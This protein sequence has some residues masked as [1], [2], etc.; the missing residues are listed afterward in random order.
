MEVINVEEVMKVL[1]VIHPI[2]ERSGLVCERQKSAR[3]GWYPQR[4][5]ACA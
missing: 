5:A 3:A 4:N 1:F 2:R